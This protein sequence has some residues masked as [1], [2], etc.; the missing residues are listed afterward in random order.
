MLEVLK[1]IY[2][3]PGLNIL[4]VHEPVI[5]AVQTKRQEGSRTFRHA[6]CR[7]PATFRQN[8]SRNSVESMDVFAY[9]LFLRKVRA[10]CRAA[11][12]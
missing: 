9:Q 11:G 1:Y 8:A 10:L 3:Y 6:G 2:L 12:I 4:W 7:C 5:L